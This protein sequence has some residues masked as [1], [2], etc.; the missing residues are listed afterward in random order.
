MTLIDLDCP[1]NGKNMNYFTAPWILLTLYRG[2][3]G[4]FLEGG[5]RFCEVARPH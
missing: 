1:Y 3:K 4:D 2:G 5:V